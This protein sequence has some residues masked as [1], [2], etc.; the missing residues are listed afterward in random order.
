MIVDTHAYWDA[1]HLSLEDMHRRMQ[2]HSVTKAIL[3]P[4][5][6][7][8]YEPDK[9]I[10]MYAIQRR[11]L[12]NTLLRPAAAA[13]SQSFYNGRGELRLLWRLFTREGQPLRKVMEPDNAGLLSAIAGREQFSQWYWLNPRLLPS[14]DQM[15]R[16]LK[17]PQVVGIKLHAYWHRFGAEDA[18][19]VFS[20]A[21]EHALPMYFI[22]GFGWLDSAIRLLQEFPSVR[23]IFGYCGFPYFDALWK[24]IR[25]FENAFV[26]TASL[27]IDEAG[28]EAALKALGAD[29]CLYGSDCPYNFR[30]LEGRFDYGLNL[31]RLRGLGL[32]PDAIE[33]VFVRN[34]R[35]VL[36]PGE[37]VPAI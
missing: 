27:H 23:V 18:R 26:D 30:D 2:Q 31:G 19:T 25:P 7:H 29:R 13:A 8:V 14:K 22:L 11:L 9:S 34:G 24:A 16:E 15:A 35:R 36:F 28:I 37:P 21:S 3:S 6:T 33:K 10:F 17:H 5:C 20:L 4:P 12:R 1:E 32:E